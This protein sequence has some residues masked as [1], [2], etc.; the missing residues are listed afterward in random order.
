M[1]KTSY[2][3]IAERGHCAECGSPISMAYK[4]EPDIIYLTAGTMDEDSIRGPLPKVKEH[5][6]L[7]EKARTWYDLPED[8]KLA[9]YSR[10][11]S[12]FQKKIEAWRSVLTSPG[13]G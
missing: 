5:I 4:C 6:F 13:L 12:V 1:K 7:E 11:S 3:D 8:D 9:K 2:S 10:F